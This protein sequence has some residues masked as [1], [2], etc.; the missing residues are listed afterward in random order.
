[1]SNRLLGISSQVYERHFRLNTFK[2]KIPFFF[3]SSKLYLVFLCQ[4]MTTPSPLSIAMT[5]SLMSS[6][7]LL[8]LSPIQP[9]RKFCS[10]SSQIMSRV[11]PLYTL[12]A[13]S[14]FGS[15]HQHF[16]V[17]ETGVI[18]FKYIRP[19]SSLAQNSSLG[20]LCP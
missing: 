3:F 10:R 20:S 6:L 12:A 7:I 4:S 11:Q 19:D 14:D 15:N 5:R 2:T 18:L 9:V 16:S 8:F 13:V 1:M 17:Q